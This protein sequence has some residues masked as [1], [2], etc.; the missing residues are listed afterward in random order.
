MEFST[1]VSKYLIIKLSAIISDDNIGE[2][3]LVD[4]ELPEEVFDFALGDVY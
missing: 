3:E 2:S 1:E 4:D